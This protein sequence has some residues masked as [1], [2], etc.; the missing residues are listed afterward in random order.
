ML[1]IVVF[2]GGYGGELFADQLEAMLPIINVIRVIDWRKADNFL[3]SPRIA[4]QTCNDALK[5]YIGRVDLIVFANHLLSATSLNYFKRKYKTQKFLGLNLPNPTTFIKRPILALTTK[6][7]ANTINYRN[8][9]FKL[10]RKI[11]TVCLDKWPGLIDDGELTDEMIRN[12]FKEINLKYHCQPAEV[13]IACSQ[14]HDI[15]PDIKNVLGKNIKI[16]D[17]FDEAISNVCK[18]LK[19]RGGTGKKRKK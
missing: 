19:I 3:K 15:I 5:P 18:I 14:F 2:D 13:I 16:Y 17:S 1:K 12:E 4:R 7:L 11:Y 9:I 6:S 10:R 8:Y